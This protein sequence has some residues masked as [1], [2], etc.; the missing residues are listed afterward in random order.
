MV[1]EMGGLDVARGE[2]DLCTEQGRL[3]Q[4]GGDHLLLTW[5]AFQIRAYVEI[6]Q[7]DQSCLLA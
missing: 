3:R 2:A 4:T 7:P 5:F 1:H 6:V